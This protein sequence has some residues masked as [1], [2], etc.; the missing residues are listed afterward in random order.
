MS[1]VLRK[2]VIDVAGDSSYAR[3]TKT[4]PFRRYAPKTL[5]CLLAFVA[6]IFALSVA[7]AADIPDLTKTP[8]ESRVG[9]TEK[10]I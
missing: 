2:R 8:G 10:I 3:E 4:H 1:L 9:L 6:S 7:L 5:A